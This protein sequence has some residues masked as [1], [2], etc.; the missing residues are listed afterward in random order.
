MMRPVRLLVRP[1]GES[2]L[3]IGATS[4]TSGNI[5]VTSRRP[6]TQSLPRK[7]KRERA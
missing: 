4:M 6:A 7:A 3:K 2:I 1:R 5:W